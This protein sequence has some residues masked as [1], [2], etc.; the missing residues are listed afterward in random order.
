MENNTS[1][2][3]LNGLLV[4]SLISNPT[5]YGLID[6]V[7]AT[8]PDRF[9]D[10]AMKSPLKDHALLHENDIDGDEY[11]FK[12]LGIWE[13]FTQNPNLSEIDHKITE[14]I[15][16]SQPALF[17]LLKRNA[18]KT[19][20]LYEL[21]FPMIKKMKAKK[22]ITE[23]QIVVLSFLA[24][25]VAK[26]FFITI[27]EDELYRNLIVSLHNIEHFTKMSLQDIKNTM[28]I[29][30][31]NDVLE[32]R[33]Q[34]FKRNGTIFNQGTMVWDNITKKNNLSHYWSDV[35][36]RHGLSEDFLYASPLT[37][38]DLDEAI[39]VFQNL[40]PDFKTMDT[41]LKNTMI[42]YGI[43]SMKLADLYQ[44]AKRKYFQDSGKFMP[45]QIDSYKKQLSENEK[46]IADKDKCI[47]ILEEK[48]KIADNKITQLERN[49][50]QSNADKSEL[51]GL[52]E[53]FF[54]LDKEEEGHPL[55]NNAA[56]EL[57]NTKAVIVGGRS[58]W[59]NR[60]KE[61]LPNAKFISAQMLN[62]D[63][64]VFDNADC[65]VIVPNYLGHPLYYKT[66]NYLQGKGKRILFLNNQNIDLV[67]TKMYE[68]LYKDKL[69][70]RAV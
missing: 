56:I 60:L 35:L 20:T 57:R 51:L 10:L 38:D 29:E 58:Q 24:I 12:M 65:V 32:Q 14:I 63:T 61:C 27:I 5:V 21:L 46:V 49:V 52:R 1:T 13:S 7:Y 11:S 43:Y 9:Y 33:E 18:N 31:Q 36:S 22:N 25:A 34:F 23:R 48:L 59:Q 66:I 39:I 17:A 15:N 19:A 68:I 2:T 6:Q 55:K 70:D 69:E 67:L 62:Y 3:V 41:E 50:S 47:G 42:L 64:H 30:E 53:L 54:S 28:S 37:R 44:D 26:T 45:L 40:Y 16:V 4:Q 8:A